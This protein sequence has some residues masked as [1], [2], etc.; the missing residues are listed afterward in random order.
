MSSNDS[1]PFNS[2]APKLLLNDGEMSLKDS[3]EIS[4][5]SSDFDIVEH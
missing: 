2:N 3:S 4:R 1:A 5:D